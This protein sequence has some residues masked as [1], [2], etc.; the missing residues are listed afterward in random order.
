[1]FNSL[2]GIKSLIIVGGGATLT[3]IHLAGYYPDKLLSV[4]KHK[5]VAKILPTE[6][7]AV[8]GI[9]LAIARQSA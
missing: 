2:R 1:M 5:H 4:A 3:A 8:G 7:N 9:R 6:L